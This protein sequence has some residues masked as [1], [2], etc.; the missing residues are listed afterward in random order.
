MGEGGPYTSSKLTMI[1]SWEDVSFEELFV[2][3]L[4]GREKIVLMTCY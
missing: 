4:L 2:H 1:F 3:R